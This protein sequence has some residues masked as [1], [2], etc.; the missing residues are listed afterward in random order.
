MC[1]LID[2]QL[3]I[4]RDS[5]AGETVVSVSLAL[6]EMTILTRQSYIV[7]SGGLGSSPYIQDRIKAKYERGVGL[8]QVLVAME[9]YVS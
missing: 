3:R 1:D 6:I 5:H 4:V 2:K 8:L 7:L 9:P